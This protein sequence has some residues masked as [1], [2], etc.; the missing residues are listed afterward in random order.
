[1]KLKHF[2]SFEL[3]A[4]SIL[5]ENFQFD[6]WN[7]SFIFIW[8]PGFRPEFSVKNRIFFDFT[9]VFRV[10]DDKKLIKFVKLK[11]FWRN[12]VFE[13]SKYYILTVEI[14]HSF[15]CSNSNFRPEL[16]QKPGFSS[17]FLTNFRVFC[18]KKL[19]KNR[20]IGDV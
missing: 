2:C 9:N 18:D 11:R 20:D 16:S 7:I 4:T 10:F 3:F 14:F 13:T 19:I 17:T 8:L 5:R 15:S 12:K 6:S 1:M